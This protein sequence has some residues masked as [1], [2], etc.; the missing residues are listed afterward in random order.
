MIEETENLE[1]LLQTSAESDP[2]LAELWNNEEDAVYDR[3]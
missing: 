3:L 2:V 1:L